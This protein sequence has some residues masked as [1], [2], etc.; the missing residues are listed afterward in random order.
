MNITLTGILVIILAIYLL[1]KQG[2]KKTLIDPRFLIL[3]MYWTFWG[4][5]SSIK[6]NMEADIMLVFSFIIFWIVMSIYSKKH[7]ICLNIKLKNIFDSIEPKEQIG[8]L[9]YNTQ[10]KFLFLIIFYVVIN[11]YI[12]SIM[13]GS[14]EAALTRFYFKQPITD[15]PSFYSTLLSILNIVSVGVLFII[16]YSNINYKQN[17]TIFYIGLLLLLLVTFPRGTRG[18]LI[19]V[20]LIPYMADILMICTGNMKA[21][22]LLSIPNIVIMSMVFF[23]ILFQT[24]FRG[25]NIESID[26]LTKEMLEFDVETGY[27]SYEEKEE[28]IMMKDYYFSYNY[29]GSQ[30]D[31]FPIYQTLWSLVTNPIPRS[32]WYDKPIT[33]GRYLAAQKSGNKTPSTASLIKDYNTSFAVGICGEGWANGGLIGVVVYSILLGIYSGVLI[34]L[35]RKFIRYSKYTSIAFALLC[36]KAASGFIRGDILSGITQNFYPIVLFIVLLYC[37]SLFK[38]NKS[39]KYRI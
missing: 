25:E 7:Y 1:I 13:Y 6:I 29:Y 5:V 32:I 14:L 24:T 38:Q 27:T 28:D 17:K 34:S 22:K 33:F 23:L 9:G 8:K 18:A 19:T 3:L 16:R 30:A 31:F 39:Y 21:K 10:I 26:G 37:I 4:E 15:V 2:V 11:L 35:S 36:Y 20:T 12:N